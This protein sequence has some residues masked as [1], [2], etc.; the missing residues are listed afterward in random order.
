VQCKDLFAAA[1]AVV[2]VVVVGCFWDQ[3][4]GGCF[5]NLLLLLLLFFGGGFFLDLLTKGL[6]LGL[7]SSGRVVGGWVGCGGFRGKE[8]R[9]FEDLTR[10]GGC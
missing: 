5:Q 4:F 10:F 1:A 9:H 2:V 6:F 3:L 8:R 7:A